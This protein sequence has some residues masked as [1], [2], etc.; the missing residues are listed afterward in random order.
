MHVFFL[1]VYW[2][3][4]SYLIILVRKFFGVFSSIPTIIPIFFIVGITL[5]ATA[6][7]W[8]PGI[9][10]KDQTLLSNKHMQ[11]YVDLVVFASENGDEVFSS[12]LFKKIQPFLSQSEVSYIKKRFYQ[13]KTLLA[14]QSFWESLYTQNPTSTDVLV[15]LAVISYQQKDIN[16]TIE[17]TKQL[18]YVDPN[19]EYLKIL[20]NL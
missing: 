2:L 17:Y 18:R 19:N 5:C 1:K 16:K 7:T 3:S 4:I 15:S 13:E 9:E 10:K 6:L 8:N 20:E 14:M 12:S 11:A